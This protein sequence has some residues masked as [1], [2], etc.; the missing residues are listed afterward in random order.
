MYEVEVQISFPASHQVK[1][2]GAELEGLHE[3]NWKVRA[4]LVGEKLSADGILVDF[5]LVK[6][7]LGQ[8]ADKLRGK[9]LAEEQ[10]L[11]G[12][13]PSAEN[14]ARYFY[15]QLTGRFGPEVRLV[16]V[17]VQEADGCWA[18]YRKGPDKLG[19]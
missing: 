14:V 3:H 9:N 19:G 11:A 7:I 17:A 18:I 4:K 15:E 12:E 16:Q 5:I 1:L 13:N 2:A 10:I 6:Q 8:I